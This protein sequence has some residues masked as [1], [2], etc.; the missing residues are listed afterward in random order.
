M[1]HTGCALL[2]LGLVGGGPEL[3]VAAPPVSLI[4]SAAHP[5]PEDQL[6]CHYLRFAMSR[7]LLV[8]TIKGEAFRID[9]AEECMVSDNYTF[10]PAVTFSHTAETR[11]GTPPG[12]KTPRCKL[13]NPLLCTQPG[14]PWCIADFTAC[15]IYVHALFAFSVARR[16]KGGFT[17]R[18]SCT[19]GEES[20]NDC[21]PFA[22]VF[23]VL[24]KNCQEQLDEISLPTVHTPARTCYLQ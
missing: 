16:G 19:K 3:S 17:M 1:I 13:C 12:L 6:P 10:Y 4:T 9:V 14:W 22:F 21:L 2:S 7:S 8:K 24:R 11:R 15:R 23:E 5:S 18:Q 20:H